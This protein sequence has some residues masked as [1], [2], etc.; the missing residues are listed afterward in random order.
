MRAQP[1]HSLVPGFIWRVVGPSFAYLCGEERSGETF[2]T[3]STV[4]GALLIALTS[5]CKRQ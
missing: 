1:P 3:A 5:V 2:Q 4:L